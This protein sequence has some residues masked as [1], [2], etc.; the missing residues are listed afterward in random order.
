MK[1]LVIFCWLVAGSV[2]ALILFQIKQE[3]RSLEQEIAQTQRQVVSDQEAVH[4]L[5]AEW[6]YLNS[7]SRIAALAER[8][9]GMAPIPA[10]RIIAFNDL[11]LP[12]APGED[13]TAPEDGDPQRP[14]TATLVKAGVKAGTE[15]PLGPTGALR[16]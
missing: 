1:R 2:T 11:P 5:E 10:E 15:T 9:L 6:S 13:G 14:S 12:S 7:P 3:V 4:V 8:H 16:Q